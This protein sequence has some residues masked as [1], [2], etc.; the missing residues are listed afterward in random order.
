MT[1]RWQFFDAASNPLD[2]PDDYD[3]GAAFGSQ[4]DAETWIGDNWPDLLADGAVAASLFDGE[5]QIYGP[6]SL[7][8]E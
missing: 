4:A 8:A 5:R 1:W 3:D 7:L 6:M 2:L